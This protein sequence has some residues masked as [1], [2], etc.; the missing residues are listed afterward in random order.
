V[1]GTN[2]YCNKKLRAFVSKVVV[3]LPISKVLSLMTNHPIP[4]LMTW[5]DQ[6]QWGILLCHQDLA[7]GYPPCELSSQLLGLGRLT[8]F[9]LFRAYDLQGPEQH[10]FPSHELPVCPYL[11]FTLASAMP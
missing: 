9:P 1:Q 6:K 11:S 10:F 4:L 5:E 2:P 3:N 8:G 7:L